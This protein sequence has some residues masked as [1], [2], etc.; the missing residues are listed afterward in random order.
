MHVC[1]KDIIEDKKMGG[2]GF[3]TTLEAQT[4]LLFKILQTTLIP[5]ALTRL[6]TFLRAMADNP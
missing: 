2:F 3:E 1:C 5:P 6:P 4:I